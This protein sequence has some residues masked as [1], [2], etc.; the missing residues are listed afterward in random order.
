M[1]AVALLLL[2]ITSVHACNHLVL[3]WNV[4]DQT[5]SFQNLYHLSGLSLVRE[6]K[7]CSL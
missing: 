7:K 4:V 5:E 1:L 6:G 3:T 2:K